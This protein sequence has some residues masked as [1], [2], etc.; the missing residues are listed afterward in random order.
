MNEN[1]FGVNTGCNMIKTGKKSKQ[2]K[3][4]RVAYNRIP[5]ERE[6]ETETYVV[7]SVRKE[8]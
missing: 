6:R 3:I 2:E 5:R 1:V 4:Q 7:P 8:M